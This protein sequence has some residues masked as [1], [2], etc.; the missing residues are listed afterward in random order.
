MTSAP[1]PARRLEVCRGDL[2]RTRVIEDPVPEPAS[3]SAVLRVER[4][5]ITAN[6]VTYAVMGDALRYWEFFPAD[7]PW[8][9][10][11]VWGFAE[12][13]EPGDTGLARGARM[14]GYVPMATHLLV[15]PSRPDGSGFADTAAH[16]AGLPAAY[17]RYRL[18]DAD[19][20][21][22]AGTEDQQALLFPLFVLSFLLDDWLATSGFLGADEVVVSSASSKSA[23]GTAHLLGRRGKVAVTG[24]TSDRHLDHV[25]RLGVYDTVVAYDAVDQLAHRPT[26]FLDFSGAASV[27]RR[28]HTRYGDQLRSSVLIGATHWDQP[29]DHP[30][31]LP[32]PAPTFFF[33]PEHLRRLHRGL[34]GD[35]VE[36]RIADSWRRYLPVAAGWIEIARPHGASEVRDAYLDILDGRADPSSGLVCSLWP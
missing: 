3:G 27:Q 12:V 28:V 31:R 20:V 36:D 2:R 13:E 16:R 14:F 1:G 21:Y 24:L 17:N 9:L 29:R 18:V 11:P 7:E 22:A 23:L 5:A 10:I 34:G 15:E 32:G 35:V 25:A 6:N 33:A 4:F 8:G 30:A 19:P 26:V